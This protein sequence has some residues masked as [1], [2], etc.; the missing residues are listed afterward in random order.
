MTITRSARVIDLLVS[1][2]ILPHTPKEFMRIC[3]ADGP[4]AC[5]GCLHAD[6]SSEEFEDW[7]FRHNF[8]NHCGHFD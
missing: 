5:L 6:V 1:R 8:C 3:S 2:A 7:K 4:C